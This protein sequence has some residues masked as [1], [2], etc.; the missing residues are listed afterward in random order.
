MV[1]SRIDR[2]S[3]HPGSRLA[4]SSGLIHAL[5][6]QVLDGA[7]KECATEDRDGTEGTHDDVAANT[8]MILELLGGVV[9]QYQAHDEIAD[10]YAS[11]FRHRCK[12]HGICHVCGFR[13][14]G[15]SALLVPHLDRAI[16]ET[17]ECTADIKRCS[18]PRGVLGH[19][20]QWNNA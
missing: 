17:E 11:H 10:T 13:Q 8:V 15:P 16:G 4:T 20:C 12:T 19:C 6:A 9:V 2:S 14:E 1:H 3:S 7:H 5:Q 18:T